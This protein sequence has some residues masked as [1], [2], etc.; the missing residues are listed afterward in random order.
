MNN[1]NQNTK[2]DFTLVPD[3]LNDKTF[4]INAYLSSPEKINIPRPFNK[5]IDWDL[6]TYGVKDIN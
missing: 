5:N 6:V 1:Y 2:A 4:R 3:E